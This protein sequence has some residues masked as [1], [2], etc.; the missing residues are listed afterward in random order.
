M[1]IKI[2]GG[3]LMALADSVPGVSGGTIAFL[4]GLYDDFIT[5]LNNIVSKDKE[6]R[7]KAIL[8][9][10]KLGSGWIVGMAMA[11]LV[12]KAVFEKHIYNISSLFLGF[13]VFAIPLIIYE[14][15][16]SFKG[17]YQNVIFTL[18]GIALVAGVTYLSTNVKGI[19]DLS[20]S[21]LTFANGIFL[22]LGAMCA[23]SAMVL[24]GISG[25]T[26]LLVF[27]IYQAVMSAISGFL[28]FEFTYMPALII[29]GIG[30]IAGVLTVVKGL[31]F[32]LEKHRSAIMYTIVGMMLGSFYAIVMG[33]TSLKENPRPA[34]SFDTFNI[35]F[36]VIGGV[37]IFG[38]QGL[39]RISKH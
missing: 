14:E 11:A 3:F 21:N 32:L 5:S 18:F 28:H 35:L 34:L 9:L 12:I 4:M 31:K 13:I 25:S 37:V 20:F 8:F 26:I 30:V 10:I 29:F 38:I 27:G 23:I 2:I 1:L 22:F 15:K 24:P 16:E 36:F 33:P 7:K 17:K 39:K 6:K 19:N